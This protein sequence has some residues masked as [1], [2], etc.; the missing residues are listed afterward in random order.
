MDEISQRE[1][2]EVLKVD[3]YFNRA[4]AEADMVGGRWK[5]P[6]ETTVTAAP[7]Y[8]RQSASSPWSRGIDEIVGVEPPLGTD[9]E[10]VGEL[11]GA[12]SAPVVVTVETANATSDGGSAP[13]KGR[14]S[15]ASSSASARSFRRMW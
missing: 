7:Q 9:N 15:L 14:G 4:Q 2:R 10:F 8:P 5:K 1:K 12:S 6:T 3:T 13:P 11:G